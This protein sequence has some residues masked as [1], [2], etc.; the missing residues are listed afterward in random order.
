MRKSRQRLKLFVDCPSNSLF[1]KLFE[2]DNNVNLRSSSMTTTPM[3]GGEVKLSS[4]PNWM[5]SNG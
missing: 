2:G 5:K 3:T 1:V 4:K